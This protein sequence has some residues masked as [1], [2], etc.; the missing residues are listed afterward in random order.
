MSPLT[1]LTPLA[2]RLTAVV[3]ALVI[4]G[5]SAGC[6]PRQDG[7]AVAAEQFFA[8]L[9]RRD[10]RAAADLSDRPTRRPTRRSTRPGPGCRRTRLDATVLGSRFTLDTGSVDYRFTWTLPRNRSWTYD[11]VLNLIRDEGRWRVRWTRQRAAPQ[12]R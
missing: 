12:A 9:G 5:T 4:V 8:E 11:G 6:A 7:P 3:C 2:T 1:S 10:T